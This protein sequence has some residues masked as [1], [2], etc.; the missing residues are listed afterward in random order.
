VAEVVD[1]KDLKADSEPASLLD[2]DDE[3]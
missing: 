1:A 3:T 2:E